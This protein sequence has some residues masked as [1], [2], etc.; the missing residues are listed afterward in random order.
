MYQNTKWYWPH[1]WK[2][3]N[4]ISIL[5]QIIFCRFHRMWQMTE[6][7]LLYQWIY[8]LVRKKN[9]AKWSNTEAIPI[10]SNTLVNKDK[11]CQNDAI[12]ITETKV[13][14]RL[15]YFYFSFSVQISFSFS[16]VL[17]NIALEEVEKEYDWSIISHVVS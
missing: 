12:L 17:K 8:W 6:S 16:S 13:D 7:V 10:L 14:P 4:V 15:N 1:L 3:L 5:D 9:R 2:I 11:W